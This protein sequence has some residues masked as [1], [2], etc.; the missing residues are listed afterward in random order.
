MPDTKP[1]PTPAPTEDA[2]WLSPQAR[3]GIA[4]DNLLGPRPY[5]HAIE[6]L[7][8]H[9]AYMDERLQQAE[10]LLL[11]KNIE[12][13]KLREE[14]SNHI[15]IHDCEISRL[16]EVIS[17]NTDAFVGMGKLHEN[18]IAAKDREIENLRCG[19]ALDK[20]AISQLKHELN[21]AHY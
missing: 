17:L 9:A 5:S 18:Q 3:R 20:R 16:S 13:A 14:F 7:L 8:A 21:V 15:R 12:I 10:E 2:R 6:S 1:T 11:S 19:K 4:Q